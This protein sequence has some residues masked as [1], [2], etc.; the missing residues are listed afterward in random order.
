MKIDDWTNL[1]ETD[2][3]GDLVYPNREIPELGYVPESEDITRRTSKMDEVLTTT[4]DMLISFNHLILL[5][6]TCH[7]DKDS[8]QAHVGIN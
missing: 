2:N 1:L 5:E 8:G 3:Q 6:I 4:Q 7:N